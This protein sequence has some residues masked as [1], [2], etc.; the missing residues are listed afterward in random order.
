ME[1]AIQHDVQKMYTFEPIIPFQVIL[2]YVNLI[3]IRFYAYFHTPS[4]LVL[5]HIMFDT[6]V[7]IPEVEFGGKY[8]YWPWGQKTNID[9]QL[10]L[11]MQKRTYCNKIC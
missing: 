5:W 9:L 4:F 8:W 2:K 6:I 3:E 7:Q 11:D 1:I 10:L